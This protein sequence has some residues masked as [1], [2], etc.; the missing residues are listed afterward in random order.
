M[1]THRHCGNPAWKHTFTQEDIQAMW[2]S[3]KETHI[4]SGQLALLPLLD[5]SV[6]FDTVEHN[7]LIQRLSHSFEIKDRALSW[8]KSYVHLWTYTIRP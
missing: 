7:L 1:E 4:H 5:M 6:A 8:L 3:S 2:E